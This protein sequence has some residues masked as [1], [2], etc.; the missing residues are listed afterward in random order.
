MCGIAGISLAPTERCH[1]T[2]VA[3]AMLREIEGRGPDATGVAWVEPETLDVYYSK[4]PIKA[5]HF[6]PK[7]SL[8][9]ARTAILHTRWA[10]KGHI[11][12]EENNHPIAVPGVVGVH[13]GQLQNDDDIFKVLSPLG[14]ERYGQVDSEAIFALLAAE[15]KQPVQERLSVLRGSAAIAWLTVD[16]EGKSDRVLHLA[17]VAA[18]PLWIGQTPHGSTLFG[19]TRTTLLAGAAAMK[20]KLIFEHNVEEGTYLR[21]RR[22]VIAEWSAIPGQ[23]AFKATSRWDSARP[24]TTLRAVPTLGAA[25]AS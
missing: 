11:S 4:M 7:M 21:V 9:G 10:T 8:H 14:A 22:G 16:D 5:R 15:V 20:T 19:S 1:P 25:V 18:S 12:I 24:G 13:N 2:L 23:P 6:I 3:A 17:R